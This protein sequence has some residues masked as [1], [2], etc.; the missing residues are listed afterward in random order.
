MYKKSRGS[1]ELIW[2]PNE[3][4]DQRSYQLS[5]HH[6]LCVTF[7]V[8]FNVATGATA[9]ASLFQGERDNKK[10]EQGCTPDT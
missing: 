7:I 10:G 1:P 6:P 2:W 4:R 3:I 5:I 9:I 8:M